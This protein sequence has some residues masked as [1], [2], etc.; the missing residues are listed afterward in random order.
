MK[1]IA[2]TFTFKRDMPLAE[3]RNPP[4]PTNDVFVISIREERKRHFQTRM[5]Q[6]VRLVR[7]WSGVDGERLHLP[8]L[9]R[10]GLLAKDAQLKRGQVGCFFSHRFIW[11]YVADNN[12]PYALVMEDDAKWAKRY[13]DARRLVTRK[14]AYLNQYQPNWDILLLARSPIKRKNLYRVTAGIRKTGPFFGLFAYIVSSRGALK[15]MNDNR[16]KTPCEP[17]DVVVSD[18]AAEGT[19]EVFALVPEACGYLTSLESD[20]DGIV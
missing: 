7:S 9:M 17:V 5:K 10:E 4:W 20:T 15:L 3:Q 12:I 6:I 14:L 13:K 11:Q 19:I 8:T 18:M 2:K 16:V 1:E